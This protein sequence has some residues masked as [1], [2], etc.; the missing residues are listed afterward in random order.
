MN[1]G[2]VQ[3]DSLPGVYEE[4]YRRIE[5]LVKKYR[6]LDI[7]LFPELCDIGYDM[8]RAQNTVYSPLP[9]L[10][11]LQDILKNVECT[12]FLGAME[13][14][15][16]GLRYNTV[17]EID[18]NHITPRYRKIHL[19]ASEKNIFTAGNTVGYTKIRD[20][21][22]GFHTCYDL[23]FPLL[24][25]ALFKRENVDVLLV[26]AAWPAARIDH[27]KTL[28]RAR[29]I[30]NQCYIAGANRCGEDAGLCLGGNSLVF[31]PEGDCLN[32][33]SSQEEVIT[34]T[35][36]MDRIKNYRTS[37]PVY[38]DKNQIDSVL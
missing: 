7:L 25:D 30:E 26:P 27:W 24:T 23:R 2:I 32:D 28:L 36:Y 19:F 3:F 5:A 21:A 29:A 35:V 34:F 31:D 18:K 15:E 12:V 4:N 22:L 9:F 33:P 17:Y 8:S 6:S 20:T 38:K 14:G 11:S 10:Q 16:P 37:F 13:F 1:I